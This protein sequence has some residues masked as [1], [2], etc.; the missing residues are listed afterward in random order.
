MQELFYHEITKNFLN[1]IRAPSM[2]LSDQ[3]S[4]ILETDLYF[5]HL[6]F[7]Q[8]NATLAFII[9]DVSLSRLTTW[10]SKITERIYNIHLDILNIGVSVLNDSS[11]V[12]HTIIPNELLDT[13][14]LV[15]FYELIDS[16]IICEFNN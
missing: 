5:L 13:D 14:K 3:L 9:K 2:T 12:V 15:L 11:I 8:H 10:Y 7:H 16:K 4:L 1:E 6:E